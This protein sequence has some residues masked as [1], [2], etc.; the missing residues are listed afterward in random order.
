[1]AGSHSNTEA[2]QS[3]VFSLFSPED[4]QRFHEFHSYD[5]DQDAE[6]QKGLQ[7]INADIAI[8][9]SKILKAKQFYFAR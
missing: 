2:Y 6:F 4:L 8:D 1:M 7:M 3:E 5:W 9:E